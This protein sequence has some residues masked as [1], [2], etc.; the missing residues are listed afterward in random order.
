MRRARAARRVAGVERRGQRIGKRERRLARRAA[1]AAA[2]RGVGRRDGRVRRRARPR[3]AEDAA[4]HGRHAR[5][6]DFL[7]AQRV[8]AV[9]DEAVVKLHDAHDLPVARLVRAHLVEIARGGGDEIHV[10]GRARHVER[11]AQVV[12]AHRKARIV[13]PRLPDEIAQVAHRRMAHR[14]DRVLDLRVVVD[15]D[16]RAVV[17]PEQR[18]RFAEPREQRAGLREVELAR[19]VLAAHLLARDDRLVQPARQRIEQHADARVVRDE[20]ALVVLRR[21]RRRRGHARRVAVPCVGRRARRRGRVGERR[22]VGR[23]GE[24]R[25]RHQ[26]RRGKRGCVSSGRVGIHHRLGLLMSGD[27]TGTAK[28]RTSP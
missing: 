8:L 19:H 24:R 18:H 4:E 25:A 11:V 15:V 21:A 28:C 9:D 12:A 7:V 13:E 23:R 20:V 22:R 5:D 17:V 6:V 27:G 14:D 3:R 10:D 16:R 2:R 1:R 26:Q